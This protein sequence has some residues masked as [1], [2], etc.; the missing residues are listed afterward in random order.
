MGQACKRLEVPEVPCL[1]SLANKGYIKGSPNNNRTTTDLS[2]IAVRRIRINVATSCSLSRRIFF[3][4]RRWHGG[5]PWGRHMR[6]LVLRLMLRRREHQGIAFAVV[7]PYC[8]YNYNT[9][10]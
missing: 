10:Q 8:S 7:W 4:R 6:L 5:R 3:V 2:R 9:S 1:A